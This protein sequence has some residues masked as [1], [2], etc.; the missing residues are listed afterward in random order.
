VYVTPAVAIST[1][2]VAAASVLT[3]ATAHHLV[4]GDTVTIAGHTGSTPSLNRALVAT[5]LTP[6]TFSVQLAVTIA[7]TGGTATR[8][9]AVEPLT[10]D[11]GKMRAELDWDDDDARDALMRQWIAAARNKVEQDTGLALLTQVRDVYMDVVSRRT[12]DLPSQSLPLQEVTSVSTVDTADATNVLASTNYVVDLVTARIG[13]ALSGSW[14]TDLRPFQP[15]LIRIVSGWTTVA[16]IPPLLIHAVGLMTAH[17]ATAGRDVA[18]VGAIS[19]VETPFGYE[20]AIAPY[21]RV[22]LA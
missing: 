22:T 2:S 8:T 14:P 15:W 3:T 4:S 18:A 20:D 17:F 13:L 21:R 16:A 7:G 6:T 11:E 12:I 10:L 1:S 9:T 19:S 5:V